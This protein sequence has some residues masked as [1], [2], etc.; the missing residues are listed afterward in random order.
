M[1]YGP[2][3]EWQT[4]LFGIDSLDPHHVRLQKI[5]AGHYTFVCLAAAAYLIVRLGLLSQAFFLTLSCSPQFPIY[6]P[7]NIHIKTRGGGSHAAK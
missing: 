7:R 3:A 6:A 2:M 4:P 1:H 5:L